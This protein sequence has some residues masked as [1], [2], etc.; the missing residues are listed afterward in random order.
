MKRRGS[1]YVV[2]LG[3]L[4][5]TATAAFHG[6]AW[7]GVAAAVDEAHLSPY[8]VPV[9][10]GLWLYAS[11]HWLFVAILAA[12][13]VRYPSRLARIV[14]G[15]AAALLAADLLLV[16]RSVGPFFGAALLAV[17]MLA[18]GSGSYLLT[19]ESE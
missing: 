1:R 9:V 19:P 3:S 13:A 2:W 18:Y 5:L 6:S 16:L 11:Y 17:S 7:P 8:L 15:L 4:V 14:L 12:V 10:K